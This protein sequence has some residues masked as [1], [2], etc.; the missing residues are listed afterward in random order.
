M[1]DD[2]H[3]NNA[4]VDNL[5]GVSSQEVTSRGVE[6]INRLLAV[7]RRL[8]GRAL[9]FNQRDGYQSPP[10]RVGCAVVNLVQERHRA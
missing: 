2:V 3:W 6:A 1:T 9:S 8:K 4:I 10:R 7:G 5:E